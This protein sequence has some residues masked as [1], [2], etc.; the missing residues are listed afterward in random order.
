MSLRLHNPDDD[1]EPDEPMPLS[2]KV[3]AIIKQG[4]RKPKRPPAKPPMRQ[5]CRRCGKTAR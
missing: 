3:K 4:Q 2:E 5:L 1:P